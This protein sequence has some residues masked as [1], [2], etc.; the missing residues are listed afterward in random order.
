MME[1]KFSFLMRNILVLLLIC[2]SF[3]TV[4]AQQTKEKRQ[5]ESRKF[6][7]SAEKAKADGNFAQSEAD[8]RQAVARDPKN[9]DASYNFG[10]LY[11]S[12]K[13]DA[14]SLQ[15]L[16]E[17]AKNAKNKALKHKAFHNL[18]NAFMNQKQY[19]QAVN[20]YENALRNDPTDNQTR[21]NLTLA[22]DK[23]KKQNKNKKDNKD[24]DKKKKN[25]N[26]DKNKKD[27]DKS[28]KGDDKKKNQGDKDKKDQNKKGQ[29]K[30]KKDK[31]D[32]NSQ[33]K[34]DGQ[35]KPQPRKGR[36]SKQQAENL[37]RAME[38]HE[39]KVQKKINA[40][41]EKAPKNPNEKD[42]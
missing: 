24:K 28:K 4:N 12:N 40:R 20:S 39:K 42:W 33:K 3:S 6:L 21:Y 14:E 30:N 17:T 1:S 29:D 22:K 37:L 2:G 23:L 8:Y 32:Q 5:K 26:K 10:N 15:H 41:K 25:Q 36:L 31:P 7:A 16:A 38:N 11:Y 27:K 18:G 9:S 13:K 34:K 19:Q 35:E